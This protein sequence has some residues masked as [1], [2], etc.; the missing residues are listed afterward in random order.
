MPTV[1][2]RR[3]CWIGDQGLWQ[4]EVLAALTAAAHSYS[5]L[6]PSPS[7]ASGR[8]AA[9][10]H[11]FESQHAARQAQL[12]AQDALIRYAADH[13]R[14][15]AW[16]ALASAAGEPSDSVG[17]AV[18]L[19]PPPAS[20]MPAL[21]GT[22]GVPKGPAKPIAGQRR[23]RQGGSTSG[24]GGAWWPTLLVTGNSAV[25]TKAGGLPPSAR[26]DRALGPASAPP[27]TATGYVL[28]VLAVS[29]EGVVYAWLPG[30]PDDIVRRF[31]PGTTWAPERDP[32]EATMAITKPFR[33]TPPVSWLALLDAASLPSLSP[34]AASALHAAFGQVVGADT[35]QLHRSER[36][37]AVDGPTVT[38]DQ[39]ATTT[40]EAAPQ[41]VVMQV[42]TT[43]G[44]TAALIAGAA[45]AAA[46]GNLA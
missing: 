3:Y 10:V 21:A 27:P 24:S 37:A 30:L 35:A 13:P 34:A 23:G 12:A 4:T 7:A 8:T 17:M 33:P 15:A 43:S 2:A 25:A 16:Q 14:I 6:Q 41:R 1:P 32:S 31:A 26:I 18:V 36:D 9:Q 40:N 39:V 5:E 22:S 29:P 46:L 20:A 45:N 38:A 42:K 44:F 11:R 19:R 28:D